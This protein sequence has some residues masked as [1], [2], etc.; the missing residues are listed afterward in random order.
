MPSAGITIHKLFVA[1]NQNFWETNFHL[2]SLVLRSWLIYFCNCSLYLYHRVWLK[3]SLHFILRNSNFSSFATHFS[4]FLGQKLPLQIS[5]YDIGVIL[6]CVLTQSSQLQ[7]LNDE[8][9]KKSLQH[10]QCTNVLLHIVM[11]L[12]TFFNCLLNFHASSI[13]IFSFLL[14]NFV[15]VELHIFQSLCCCFNFN[16]RKTISVIKSHFFRSLTNV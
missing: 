11:L 4:F 7:C 2:C 13:Y 15:T 14:I 16:T 9:Y 6:H 3:N 12:W 8:R 5:Q 1:C 10:Q